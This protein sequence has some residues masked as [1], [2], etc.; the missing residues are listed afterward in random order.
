MRIFHCDHCDNLVVFENTSCVQCGHV[1]AFL[2]DLMEI[3]SLD[4]ADGDTWRSPHPAAQ[5]QTYRLCGNYAGAQRH[6]EIFRGTTTNAGDSW[7]WTQVTMN[8][9]LDN[10]RPIVVSDGATRKVLLWLRGTYRSYTDYQQQVLMQILA[11]GG[12]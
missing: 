10:L 4:R 3:G 12:S 7:Q 11:G 5:G 6:Y 9:T 8:S 2:P 1:L